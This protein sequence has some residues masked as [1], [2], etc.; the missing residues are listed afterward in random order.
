MANVE[1]EA[2]EAMPS[3]VKRSVKDALIEASK[4]IDRAINSSGLTPNQ[5]LYLYTTLIS[6]LDT[7]VFE[8]ICD[9]EDEK[10]ETIQ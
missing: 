2:V 1:K 9:D 5:E 10:P 6:V 7:L 4:S 8:I 3:Q